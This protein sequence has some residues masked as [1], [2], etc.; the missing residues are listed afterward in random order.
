M[1]DPLGPISPADD[2]MGFLERTHF[3]KGTS[4]DMPPEDMP[5]SGVGSND[6]FS[7]W[8]C[9]DDKLYVNDGIVRWSGNG[10]KWLREAD[11][12][13]YVVINGGSV[14]D[15]GFVF[16]EVTYSAGVQSA[17]LRFTTTVPE[18]DGTSMKKALHLAYLKD[19]KAVWYRDC[20]GDWEIRS[21]I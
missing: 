2:F 15:P 3:F 18:D 4:V 13:N 19:G 20:R 12:N 6:S 16:I 5:V 10:Y 7:F 11:G 9:V 17:C 21:V 14:L 8:K 1:P